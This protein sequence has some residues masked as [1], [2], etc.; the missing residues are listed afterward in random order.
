MLH[1]FADGRL[2]LVVLVAPWCDKGNDFVEKELALAADMM[3]ETFESHLPSLDSSLPT[4]ARKPLIGTLDPSAV[5]ED[6]LLN[7]FGDVTHY[8]ALKFVIF[9]NG[10]EDGACDSS[11]DNSEDCENDDGDGGGQIQT[12]DYIG[13]RKTAKDIYDSVLMYWYRFV[14]S[15]AVMTPDDEDE[16][17]GSP[18][19]TFSSQNELMTFLQSHGDSVLRPAQTRRQHKSTLEEEVFNFYMGLNEDNDVAGVFH[20]YE[21]GND[22][23][24][25][26]DSQQKYTQEI[27]PFILLVQ[28]RSQLEYGEIN[29]DDDEVNDRLSGDEIILAENQRQ[30]VK[31]FDELAQEMVHR[32]DVAFVALNATLHDVDAI[33]PIEEACDVLFDEIGGPMNGDV[34][35]VRARRYVS[36]SV[37]SDTANGHTDEKQTAS[38]WD[39]HR[40]RVIHNV[41]TDWGEVKQV[42]PHAIF[43]PSALHK[44]MPDEQKQMHG[45]FANKNQQTTTDYIQ[46]NLVAS[47]IV[48]STPTVMWYDKERTAQLAFPWY[49]KIHAVLFVDMGLSYKEWRPTSFNHPPWPSS[50]NHSTETATLLLRQQR[51][52]QMFYTAALGHRVKRPDDDMVFLIVPSSETRIMTTFGIDIWSPLDEALFNMSYDDSDEEDEQSQSSATDNGYCNSSNNEESRSV[53]P[54][55]M[56]TDSSGRAGL[57]SSRYYLCSNDILSDDNAIEEFIDKFFEGTIGKP[58]TRSETVSPNT[59]RVSETTTTTLTQ[60]KANVT[61][62]TGNTFESL[63]M[64]RND[65]HTMLLI[66]S[67]TC[68]HCKRFNIFWNELSLLVQAMNWSSVINVAKIDVSK[69]D[70]PH[71][72]INAWDLPSVYYFPA[73]EKDDPIEMTPV[74]GKTNPQNDYDE[75]LSWVTSGYDI[76]KWMISQNKLELEHLLELGESDDSIISADRSS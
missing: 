22:S 39:Q 26:E 73:F 10:D 34:A 11:S 16:K 74:E 56:I 5:D 15:N 48:H 42:S 70:V 68:G 64:D 23:M 63:V 50:L 33:D 55:M 69:N 60:D 6:I 43:V 24:S 9:S 30:A 29:L 53:L 7:L 19:F 67:Y 36:Y 62:V 18:I 58:F 1:A 20:P 3:D 49:R 52:I 57:Q 4:T 8:P 76:I 14:V 2:L 12:W 47:T 40:R 25:K 65:E 35:F 71:E 46:S 44:S 54:I 28:C 38:M 72:K 59:K 61:I 13:P 41:Q 37:E 75:G 45:K 66:Q 51:A 32:V 17:V 27:D 21:L 31:D